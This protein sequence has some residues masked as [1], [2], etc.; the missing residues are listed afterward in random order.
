MPITFS[1]SLRSLQLDGFRRANLAVLGVLALMIAWTLWLLLARVSL[2]EIS[3]AARLE[4]ESAVHPV[5]VQFGGRVVQTR[6]QLGAEVKAGDVLVELDTEEH[7]LHLEEQRSLLSGLQNQLAALRN[8]V[9]AQERAYQQEKAAAPTAV[10]EANARQFEAET[11]AQLA[12]KEAERMQE[13]FKRGLI[14]EVEFRRAEAD[15]TRSRAAAEALRL[16]ASRLRTEQGTKESDQQAKLERLNREVAAL[17][18]QIATT[19]KIIAREQL[20]I[21]EQYIRAPI[22]GRIGEITEIQIGAVVKPSD[23]LATIVPSGEIRIVANFAV[24]RALGRV[25]SG[26]PANMRLDAYPWTQFGSLRA[27]VSNVAGEP[28]DGKVRVE[29]A[30]QPQ[31]NSAI[32]LQHGLVGSV[33]VEVDR[34]S[35]SAMIL[36]TA[37]ELMKSSKKTMTDGA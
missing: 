12:E 36:R 15:A 25:R 29:L 11:S 28:R 17:A 16:T 4:V 34:V 30:I 13:L 35:P 14:S 22:S 2:Y 23:K 18:G 8:E 1:R 21:Q 7:K 31:A 3:D 20:E 32:I 33:E 5:A 6:L 37:S 10:K 24:G 19:E 27:Q 26:Q 9:S